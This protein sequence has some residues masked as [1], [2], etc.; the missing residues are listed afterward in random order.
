MTRVTIL[1]VI[2][3]P[4][5]AVLQRRLTHVLA[6]RAD[7]QVELRLIDSEERAAESGMTGSPTLLVDGVDPFAIP[8]QQPSL[9]CRL[10]R[11]DTGT[12]IGAPSL[13]QLHAVFSSASSHALAV[14]PETS[15]P[16]DAECGIAVDQPGAAAG[17]LADWRARST[18]RDLAAQAVHARI[19]RAFA[20]TG[21]PPT[22]D[23][24]ADVL[25]GHDTN[26]DQVLAGLHADDVIRLDSAGHI[27]V[28]YPFSTAPT[29]HRVTLASGVTVSAMCAIDALGIPAML[30]TDAVITSTDPATAAAVTVV[31]HDGHY[32]WDP[33]AAV[34]FLSANAGGGPSADNCCTTLNF[35]SSPDSATA[36]ISAHPHIPGTVLS[37]TAA[38]EHG[39]R[40][41]GTLLADAKPTHEPARSLP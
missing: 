29:P 32:S 23:Q 38:Q 2:D 28:A 1:H 20:A 8:G 34:V 15:T 35:F 24:L 37:A 22:R 19:L 33:A 5:V 30:D 13:A 7:V 40:I 9:S 3:C 41:F 16:D 25:A 27:A 14:A 17:R 18:P 11:D 6:D 10:Y 26:A 12:V 31:C 21:R 36:W 39:Q 4:N